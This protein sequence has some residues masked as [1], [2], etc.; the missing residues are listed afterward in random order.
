MK[1]RRAIS[2]VVAAVLLVIIAVAAGVMIWVWM[3]G[4]ASKNPATEPVLQE[5]FV[6]E[7]IKVTS[8]QPAGLMAYVRNIGGTN[9]TITT[10]YLLDARG[11]TLD[12]AD[13]SA[14]LAPGE[15]TSINVNFNNVNL[16]AGASY[17]LKLVTQ[18]GSEATYT[19]SP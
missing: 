10:A 14:T 18:R 5:R 8:M 15:V 1:M 12:K 4:I 2:P 19:F 11:Q 3:S 7:G 13:V 17:T 9:I 6:I 16:T